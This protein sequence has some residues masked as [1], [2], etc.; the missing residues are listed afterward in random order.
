MLNDN[1]INETAKRPPRLRFSELLRDRPETLISPLL[2]VVILGGWELAVRFFAIPAI[3]VPAPSA[4]FS[5]LL[6]SFQS[7]TF[8]QDLWI[9]VF[10]TIAGFVLGAATGLGLGALI[11]QFRLLERVLFPYVVAFQTIPIVAIA[12]ILVI[13]FGYGL[14]SKVI[15]TAI[16]AFFPVVANTIVGL[17]AAPPDQVELLV[18]F[19]AD[20]W[21]VFWKLRVYQ[22]LPF[23]FAALD[24]AIVLSVIGAIV[25][26]FVGAQAGLGYLIMQRNFSMDMAGT[27]SILVVLSIMGI[28]LHSA[29]QFVHR[30]VVFWLEPSDGRIVGG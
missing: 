29:A 13:W 30:R 10:E 26:E 6:V 9:T 15:I 5:S 3:I 8:L 16:I 1:Q 27:F 18:A 7:S 25:G 20:R 19:T 14:T 12:P 24:V 17:R 21:Q 11:G 22:A 23:I 2:L 4:V 28:V